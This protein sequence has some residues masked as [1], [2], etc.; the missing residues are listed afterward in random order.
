M[1]EPAIKTMTHK[2]AKECVEKINA[3]MNNIRALI[4]DLYER[5]GWAALGYQSW[6]EC[7]VAEFKQGEN[8]LY[9]QLAAAQ[10]ER[11]ICTFV[12]SREPIPE[13]QLRP[14]AKLKDNPDQQRE[15]WQKAVDTAPKGKV[16]AA[17]VSKIVKEMT[18]KEKPVSP[19]QKPQPP[20]EAM[21][22][23]TF[24]ISHLERIRSD[25]PKKNEAIKKIMNWCT[26]NIGKEK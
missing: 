18:T 5:E 26:K 23:A 19:I 12:Q 4:L 21:G 13:S 20:S 9:K 2:E 15:A 17:H 24:I 14:L 16:T 10:T 22:I 3:D 11:N 8:Y 25:D 6:R 7:V 1:N